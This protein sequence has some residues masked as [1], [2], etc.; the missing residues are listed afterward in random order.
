[1]S[2]TAI[3]TPTDDTAQ[4]TLGRFTDVQERAPHWLWPGWLPLGKLA[5]LDGDPGL[6]KSTLMFDL[7]ARVSKDGIMPDG[8]QGATG[9]VIIANAEDDLH[10]TIKPRLLAAG[11]NTER[12][13]HISEVDGSTG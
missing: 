8:S 11:A 12:L 7:A 9:S 5:V 1:M 4:T 10:D 13:F 2:R 6:G 3:E